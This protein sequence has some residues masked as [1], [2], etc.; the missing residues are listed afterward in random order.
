MGIVKPHLWFASGAEEAA[1]FY[2]SV[3]PNSR[4]VGVVTAP[5]G[6]PDVEEGAPFVIDLELDGMAVQL[7]N[8]GPAFTLDEAFSL[9][10][11]CED[12]AQVDHYWAALTADGGTPGQCGWLTDRFGV[13][14]QVV[15]KQ[16]VEIFGDYTTD[17]SRRALAAMFTMGRLD[18]A[19]LEAAAAG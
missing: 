3:I 19:A 4:V 17:G 7:L 8:A 16:L 11:E 18:I 2:A 6:V 13:S 15:P 1:A 12:Q 5:P 14:W 9:V 10:V